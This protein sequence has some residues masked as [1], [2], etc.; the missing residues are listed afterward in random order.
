MIMNGIGNLQRSWML[1]N[2]TMQSLK[3]VPYI[4]SIPEKANIKTVRWL[5]EK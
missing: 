5:E 3:D 1:I 4:Y 2:M